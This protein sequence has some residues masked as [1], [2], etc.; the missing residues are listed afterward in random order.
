MLVGIRPESVSVGTD[1]LP[2]TVEVVE[3]L[4]HERI[5]TCSLGDGQEAVVRV[6]ARHGPLRRG[7]RL[8]LLVDPDELVLFDADTEVR[9]P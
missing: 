4:G 7:Q 8:H 2:A 3:S 9:I 6:D 1:G 5:V